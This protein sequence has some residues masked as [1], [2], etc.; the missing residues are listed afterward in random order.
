MPHP[1]LVAEPQFGLLAVS[2]RPQGCIAHILCPTVRE[3]QA[4]LLLDAFEQLAVRSAGRLAVSLHDVESITAAG[5]NALI[6]TA[7]TCHQLDGRLVVFGLRRSLR[8]LLRTTR[9]NRQLTVARDAA[10][11]LDLLARPHRARRHLDFTRA[12]A[13]GRAA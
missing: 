3:R 10:E 9:L 12:P 5:L 6:R 4:A 11:A 8:R 1:V 7:H 2:S 13:P